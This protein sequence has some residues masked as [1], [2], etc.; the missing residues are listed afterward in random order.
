M[1]TTTKV[2]LSTLVIGAAIGA[3][4]YFV[5]YKPKHAKK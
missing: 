4:Y 3:T 2:I 5:V 1:S